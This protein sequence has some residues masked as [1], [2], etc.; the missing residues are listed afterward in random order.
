MEKNAES[1]QEFISSN[2]RDGKL[3]EVRGFRPKS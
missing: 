3:M 1:N 2:G